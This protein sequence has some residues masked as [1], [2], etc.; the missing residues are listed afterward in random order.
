MSDLW[1]CVGIER[2][3]VPESVKI[4][5]YELPF[6]ASGIFFVLGCLLWLGGNWRTGFDFF[7]FGFIAGGIG[8]VRLY[9]L[10]ALVAI[11]IGALLLVF[12]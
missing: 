6:V 1:R 5:P 2:V 4:T 11:G 8:I 9:F 3:L 7:G 10:Y 12:R